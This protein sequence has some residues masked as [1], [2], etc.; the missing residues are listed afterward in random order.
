MLLP[1]L[2]LSCRTFSGALLYHWWHPVGVDYF[3]EIEQEEQT[4]ICI[5]LCHDYINLRS[6]HD[7]EKRY[8]YTSI[9]IDT[10]SVQGIRITFELIDDTWHVKMRDEE[11]VLE[12]CDFIDDDTAV[13]TCI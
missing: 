3:H 2:L 1:L 11:G 9:D 8:E 7:D 4:G 5:C 10:I 6:Y 13:T 12:D